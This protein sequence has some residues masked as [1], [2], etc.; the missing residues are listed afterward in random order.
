M[1]GQPKKWTQCRHFICAALVMAVTGILAAA[2]KN[3]TVAARDRFWI[4]T[5]Y[6]GGDN[7]YLESG[8]VR[9]GSRMTP[10]EG[11]FWLGVPNLLFI[12]SH[13]TPPLPG[14][15]QA[16]RAKTSFQQY[17]ISFQS[18]DR[19]VW[20]VVGS[21]GKGSM[22]ELPPVLQLAKQFPNFRGVYLDDFI[23]D[24]KK[25]PD[26]LVA[27]RPALLP[28][29]LQRARQQMKPVGR[30]LDIWV[31]LYTHEIN[32]A[33]KTASPAFRGCNPQLATFLDQFDV[34][35]LWTW[36]SD[37][38]RELEENFA[39]LEKIAPKQARI[40]LGLYI[41]D[42]HNRKPVPLELMQHQC[43]LGLKWL[44]ECRIHDMIFLANTVLD[45]GLPSAEF[46][47]EWIRKVGG[48]KV[49]P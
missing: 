16:W 22:S 18:L 6:P 1:K 31:T 45:V 33:R 20:S 49:G 9:G 13:E 41:W 4:F 26:G 34:L 17:A 32:T 35:T 46:A 27:G 30:P 15:E 48:E 36:N 7:S 29:E 47:R 23:I 5:V 2:E 25:Q 40:A 42:F 12:R 19:V 43:E 37:E 39:A 28:E 38:L 14:L 3:G 44:K 21:G 11:A 8:G 10:A 24:A